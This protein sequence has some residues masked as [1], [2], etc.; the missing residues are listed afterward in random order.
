[1]D[2]WRDAIIYQVVVDRFANGD[3][4]NDVLNGVG[5]NATSLKRHQGGDWRG[6]R[7]NLD[8]IEELGANTIW[9]SPIVANVDVTEV[10]DGYHGY[11][12]RDF[13]ELNPRF[14]DQGELARLVADVHA[15]DMWIVVDVVT[16]HAGRVFSYDLN[17]NG[18]VDVGEN[19]PPYLAGGYDAPLLWRGERPQA[20]LAD[21][22]TTLTSEDFRRRGRSG[23]LPDQRVFGDFPT[24]LRDL[25]TSSERVL[26]AMVDTYAHW[27][28]TFDLDG[29]RLDAVPHVEHAF[30]SAFCAR[31]RAKLKAAGKER[32]LLIGEV[33]DGDPV[34]RAS[35][36]ERDMLDAVFDFSFKLDLIG[37]VVLDGEA[38]STAAALLTTD[39]LLLSD[40]PQPNG[41]GSNPW[42]LR[43]VIID[44][45]D[46]PRIRAEL[47][48]DEVVALALTLLFTVDGL[49]TLYYGTEQ[50]FTGRSGGDQRER[51]WDS[52]F[53]RGATFEL[54]QRLIALRASSSALRYGELTL[55]YASEE[56]GFSEAPDAGLLAYERSDGGD[57]LLIVANTHATKRSSVELETGFDDGLVFD[58]F[59]DGPREV[60]EGRVSVSLPP[61]GTVILRR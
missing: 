55:R 39:R 48:R 1:M 40:A 57:R 19:E 28:L 35:F 17:A 13:T 51:M 21:G 23:S 29:F 31:L 60:R 30:W 22:T 46:T 56:D 49:P 61:R 26:A 32:F 52:D 53:E 24:G 11:W 2:D 27:A 25:N 43:G 59:G 37:R 58:V 41:A 6:L 4:S 14:G 7:E 18:V 12:A 8:Y 34:A 15:R 47:N 44:N 16:N 45:H 33:F 20:F 36:Q 9:I 3:T 42:S 5:P 50:D 10:E 38:P 54:I